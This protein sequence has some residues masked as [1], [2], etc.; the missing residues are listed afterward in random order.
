[1]GKKL[2][3]VPLTNDEIKELLKDPKNWDKLSKEE[4]EAFLNGNNLGL[5]EDE[6]WDICKRNG[7]PLTDEQIRKL[8]NGEPLNLNKDELQNILGNTKV[9]ADRKKRKKNKGLLDRHSDTDMGDMEK[10]NFY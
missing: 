7:I 1:M 9:I 4:I 6:I 2:K 5:T 3:G 8:A 10:P